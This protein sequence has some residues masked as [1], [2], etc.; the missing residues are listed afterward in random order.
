MSWSW[1][2]ERSSGTD[3]E[4]RS[5]DFPTQ[6]DAESWIGETW[7]EL[8]ESGVERVVLLEESRVV[9]GPMGLRPA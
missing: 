2:Y 7:R 5:Q 8:L 3:G 1:R 6:S 9:Y 4:L